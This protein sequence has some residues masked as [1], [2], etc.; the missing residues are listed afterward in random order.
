MT[1]ERDDAKADE[2]F[3]HPLPDLDELN[4]DEQCKETYAW[5]G[6]ALYFAQV[7]EQGMIH[8]VY[9]AQIVNGTMLDE[10]ATADEF[11]AKVDRQT[12]G[13][14]LRRV[15][16]H[17]PMTPGLEELC[18]DALRLRNFLAHSFFSERSELPFSQEGRKLMLEE[19]RS[20]I[21]TFRRADKELEVLMIAMHEQLGLKRST[22]ERIFEELRAEVAK[23][24]SV[25]SSREIV[26][27]VMAETNPR[28]TRDH[29][30]RY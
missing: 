11:H 24:T 13:T 20:M 22:V 16:Q 30:P 7:F 1:D 3:T 4:E 6:L 10:F 28:W 17:V 5:A 2:F 14:I 19:L 29:S 9:V 27:E 12:A 26:D 15:R 25:R 21:T 18:D 8:T 23:G